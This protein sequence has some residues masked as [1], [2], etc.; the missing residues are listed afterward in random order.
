MDTQQDR[1][2][3]FRELA[4]L[5]GVSQSTVKRWRNDDP[6]FPEVTYL[7]ERLPRIRLSKAMPYLQTRYQ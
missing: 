2:I 6:E 4:D 3:T 7:G 1:L 5:G